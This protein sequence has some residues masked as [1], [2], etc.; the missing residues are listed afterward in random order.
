ML[1]SD[2]PSLRQ[3]RAFESVARL[4]SVGGAAR[5]VNVSQPGVTQALRALEAQLGARLFERS[6]SGCYA[7]ELGA[8]LLPRVRRIFDHIRSGLKE[9]GSQDPGLASRITRPQLRSLIAISENPSFDAAARALGISEPSLHRSARALERDLG[10]RLFQRTARGISTTAQG[11]ELARRFRV[12]LREM[13]YGLEELA[14]A[15]GHIVSRVA[16]GNIPHSATQILSS[17]VRELLAR[18]PGARVQIVDGH[19]EDLLDALR[20]GTLDLLFG[21][22]RRPEWAKDVREEMLFTNSYVV[23]A[24][25][26]HP[27]CRLRRPRLRDLVGYEW[28]M[29]GP[30]TPRQQALR[31]LLGNV[32]GEPRI[33]IEATSLQVYRTILTTT[34]RLT[35][36]SS[37][38]AA[39]GD[40]EALTV[41]PFRSP[42]LHRR[43]GIATR[44]NWEPTRTHLEFLD[45]LRAEARRAGRGA[46]TGTGPRGRPRT[47]R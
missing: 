29:P 30:M 43:D 41:L 17:A 18:Y 47:V 3:L 5:E 44:A 25:N 42:H 31:R 1:A 34:D 9:A 26:R 7:T 46:A 37:F 23:V 13:E 28:I 36:M 8:I 40:N 6:R 20:A 35:L 15:R 45:L 33:G 11:S 12:A 24:R 32:A 19:Y 27:L 38:E 2:M 39:R 16:I 4:G 21:V 22:L 14:A 10:R